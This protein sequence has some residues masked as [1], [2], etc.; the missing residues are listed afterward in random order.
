MNIKE[1]AWEYTSPHMKEYLESKKKMPYVMVVKLKEMLKDEGL[2]EFDKFVIK[3]YLWL[4]NELPDNEIPLVPMPYN[5][6]KEDMLIEK[7]KY[8]I[9]VTED[10]DN[11]KRLIVGSMDWADDDEI[12]FYL[13]HKKHDKIMEL[14]DSANDKEALINY[15]TSIEQWIENIETKYNIEMSTC[16]DSKYREIDEVVSSYHN[17]E[18]RDKKPYEDMIAY[19]DHRIRTLAQ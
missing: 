11:K 4:L 18:L 9:E 2:I 1:L 17:M 6:Y 7:I 3:K 16:E 19:I 10:I 8:Q 12:T 14:I 13:Y 15:R 5:T